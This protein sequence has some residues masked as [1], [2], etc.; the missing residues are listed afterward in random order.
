MY[1]RSNNKII[2][3]LLPNNKFINIQMAGD[4]REL[5]ELISTIIDL[6]PDQIKG[7]KDSYGN[8][9][10][11]SS[12]LATDIINQKDDNY[13]ELIYSKNISKINNSNENV[14][15]NTTPNVGNY[16][17][18]YYFNSKN[19]NSNNLHNI[20]S[21]NKIPYITS[22]NKL[23]VNTFSHYETFNNNN[24]NKLTQ[25][26]SM[27]L[28][29]RNNNLNFNLYK[30]KTLSLSANLYQNNNLN[31]SSNFSSNKI[32]V[33]NA[34]L[35][36]LY[37]NNQFNELEYNEILKF[38]NKQDFEI[39]KQFDEF[40]NGQ[41]DEQSFINNIK[42]LY[43]KKN[44]YSNLNDKEKMVKLNTIGP[45]K[46]SKTFDFKSNDVLKSDYDLLDDSDDIELNNIF[47]EAI[48]KK[49][50]NY[51]NNK[52][53][54]EI[55]RLIFKYDNEFVNQ[56]LKEYKIDKNF[57]NLK[58]VIKRIIERHKKKTI[59][60]RHSSHLNVSQK[61]LK[62]NN[63][64]FSREKKRFHSSQ[65][66]SL[67]EDQKKL[68]GIKPILTENSIKYE[69]LKTENYQKP[70]IIDKMINKKTNNILK[71]KNTKNN[72]NKKEI[73]LIEK[74]LS[75]N[76]KIYY[77]VIIKNNNDVYNDIKKFYKEN[78]KKSDIKDLLNKKIYE[79]IISDLLAYYKKINNPI[80]KKELDIINRLLVEEDKKIDIF[81]EQLSVDKR[82][83]SFFVDL[84][85]SV[86]KVK[87]HLLVTNSFDS[88]VDLDVSENEVNN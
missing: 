72:N 36:Q 56:S 35:N 86:E 70:I 58:L 76:Y 33:Y 84:I 41:L 75:K 83:N 43:N 2:K 18:N 60:N 13:F 32:Q 79:T 53:D 37:S 52:T 45:E 22:L 46:F 28:T 74:Y 19:N 27:S 78:E 4:E 25:S 69:P 81:F 57:D 5:K 12:A 49:L 59:I 14:V 77:N 47:K 24:T 44:I 10:T 16:Y 11:I 17:A 7:I 8:Y 31:I 62:K 68:F 29:E 6:N 42:Y 30:N 51:F 55:L 64:V 54:I 73:D 34:F 61:K 15:L 3:L 66:S 85:N 39:L 67:I 1:Y 40:T 88:S 87:T 48:Y 80:K 9:F 23:N 26:N 38:I 20:Y 82:L 21:H 71:K 65:E 50:V 63:N